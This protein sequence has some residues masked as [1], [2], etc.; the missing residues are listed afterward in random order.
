MVLQGLAQS[1][2]HAGQLTVGVLVAQDTAV[3]PMLVFAQSGIDVLQQ[4]PLLLVW[5]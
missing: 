4:W 1:R 5:A 2:T 3:V